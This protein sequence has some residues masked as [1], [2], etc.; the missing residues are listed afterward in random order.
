MTDIIREVESKDTRGIVSVHIFITQFKE[1]FDIRTTMLVRITDLHGSSQRMAVVLLGVAV[2]A[3]ALVAVVI[4][5][6]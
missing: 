4:W 5:A 2:V 1:K 6:V 3:V